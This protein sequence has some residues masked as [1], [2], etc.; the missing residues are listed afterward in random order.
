MD[1]SQYRTRLHFRSYYDSLPGGGG[2]SG[3]GSNGSGGLGTGIKPGIGGNG[4]SG[5]G[6]DKNSNGDDDAT[7]NGGGNHPAF[8]P[9]YIPFLEEPDD[10]DDILGN[11]GNTENNP[12]LPDLQ[13]VALLYRSIFADSKT[14]I[15]MSYYDEN[16]VKTSVW[17]YLG[18]L[19][20][21]KN[22]ASIAT[23]GQILNLKDGT[24]GGNDIYGNLFETNGDG[25]LEDAYNMIFKILGSTKNNN[26]SLYGSDLID[27]DDPEDL[28]KYLSKN[29]SVYIKE[30][31]RAVDDYEGYRN[32]WVLYAILNEKET[33]RELLKINNENTYVKYHAPV[34]PDVIGSDKDTTDK[35]YEEYL[36]ELEAWKRSFPR[37]QKHSIWSLKK[38]RQIMRKRSILMIPRSTVLLW[39]KVLIKS[40]RKEKASARIRN[41]SEIKRQ[42]N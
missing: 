30:L 13:S 17:F 33:A 41:I 8:G 16:G 34:Q 32:E 39:K 9:P 24:F 6:N 42:S 11:L 40:T 22:L 29:S 27:I 37:R 12:K 31:Q 28:S 14:R 1:R 23:D 15:K 26:T 2:G 5:K 7:D 25:I 36:A 4:G 35:L 21:N 18:L 20:T 10:S 38:I 3:S 19:G